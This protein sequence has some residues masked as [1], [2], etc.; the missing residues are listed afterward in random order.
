[1]ALHAQ[2]MDWV[3]SYVARLQPRRS[4]CST[5]SRRLPST[6][7]ASSDGCHGSGSSTVLHTGLWS[8]LP[9]TQPR[10]VLPGTGSG[11]PS[12]MGTLGSIVPRQRLQHCDP[13]ATG[14]Q[15]LGC[16]F[17]CFLSHR[18]QP[19]YGYLILFLHLSLF[20]CCWQR[21]HSPC[22]WHRLLHPSWS[23]SPQ[24]CPSCS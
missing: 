11:A 23:F 4:S 8:V 17:R 13:Y 5:V 22:G 16:R 3:H 21:C 24:Q 20:H 19:R 7:A 12:C 18:I 9:G 6:P 15:R 14:Q 1:M 10:Y 2:S